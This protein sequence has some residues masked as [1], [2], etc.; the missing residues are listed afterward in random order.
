MVSKNHKVN[1]HNSY[2]KHLDARR[3]YGRLYYQN[4]KERILA[5]NAAYRRANKDKVAAGHKKSHAKWYAKNR[6]VTLIKCRTRS[7]GV[8]EDQIKIL[9]ARDCEICNAPSTHIDHDHTSGAIRG[10]LCKHCNWALGHFRDDISRLK[11]AII[12]LKKYNSA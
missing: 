12:Y 2:L 1:N 11:K 3:A 8:S 6:E 7:Y 10:A 4:N 9:L 5:R